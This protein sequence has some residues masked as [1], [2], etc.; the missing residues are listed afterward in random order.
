MPTFLSDPPQVLYLLLGGLLVITGL[1][2]AQRQD[3]RSVI[4]F[5]GAFF[6]ILVL[7]VI[8]RAVETP[9]EEAVRRTQV[10][11]MAADAQ[12]AG[13]FSPDVF[14]EQLADRVTVASGNETGKVLTRDEVKR[15]PFWN[16]L[17]GHS[18]HVAV[19]GFSRD[20]AKQINDNTVEIGFMGKGESGSN[21][22]P[23]YVRATYTKQPD[24]SF[25]LS[26]LRTF[27]PINH[28]EGLPIPGFP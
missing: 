26:A 2:A 1:V 21:Q 4:P 12:N 7:F 6:L 14:G 8:D 23:A 24:G 19:W 17:R 20:D 25:K 11:A 18:V 13:T 16:S 3:R 5:A 22:I 10:L 15:H 9:R 27:D 28:R